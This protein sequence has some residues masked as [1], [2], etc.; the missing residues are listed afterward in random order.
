[1][2]AHQTALYTIYI[3]ARMTRITVF[4]SLCTRSAV[5]AK[6]AAAAA[7]F[8]AAIQ[9]SLPLYAFWRSSTLLAS[10]ECYS[11]RVRCLSG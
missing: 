5:V 9:P 1:M 3:N 11:V 8:V 10:N 6:A 4:V 2:V 7:A